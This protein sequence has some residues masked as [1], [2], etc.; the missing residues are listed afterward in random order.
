VTFISKNAFDGCELAVTLIGECAFQHSTIT[1]ITIPACIK[2]ICAGAFDCCHE[3]TQV[4]FQEGSQLNAIEHNGFS[5]S[6]L[7]SITLPDSVTVID[8]NAFDSCEQL[9]E[10]IFGENSQL[11]TI[12]SCA[13]SGCLQLEPMALPAGVRNIDETAF[14]GTSMQGVQPGQQN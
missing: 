4:V 5:D 12:E 10:V 2:S 6:G 3:L 1:K 11:Q 8:A 13:F 7:T 14:M 9:S